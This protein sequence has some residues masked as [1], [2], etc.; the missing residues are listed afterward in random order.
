MRELRDRE[1]VGVVTQR[2][3]RQPP[4][5]DVVQPEALAEL[6]EPLRRAH[7]S[8]VREA[9]SKRRQKLPSLYV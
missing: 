1:I 6:V 3:T 2:P 4:S 7:S 5:R 9:L 8:T